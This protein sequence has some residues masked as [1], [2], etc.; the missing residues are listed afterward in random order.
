[1]LCQPGK[2]GKFTG[3]QAKITIFRGSNSGGVI[4]GRESPY[5]SSFITA[6]QLMAKRDEQSSRQSAHIEEQ[7]SQQRSIALQ[8]PELSTQDSCVEETGTGHDHQ[9]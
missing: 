1:M 8:V 3:S 5:S 7:E 6:N 9:H 4:V 2:K